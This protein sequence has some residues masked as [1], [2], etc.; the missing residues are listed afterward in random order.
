MANAA[1]TIKYACGTGATGTAPSQHTVSSGS[2][3]TPAA[4]TCTRD[5]YVFSHY[6]AVPSSYSYVNDG[7]AQPGTEYTIPFKSTSNTCT[8]NVTL[9]LTAQWVEQ[10]P[11]KT[12]SK[13][14]T[15]AQLATRQPTIAGNGANKLMLFSDTTD[16]EILNRDIV[17]TLGTPDSTTG[18]YSNTDADSAATRG[19]INKGLNR[20]QDIINGEPTQATTY[21]GTAGTLGSKPIYSSTSKAQ[22]ALIQADTLNTGIINAVNS[23]LTQIDEN[24]NPSSTGTLWRINDA[25]SI[26]DLGLAPLANLTSGATGCAKYLSGDPDYIFG[27]GCLTPL[28]SIGSWGAVFTYNGSRVQV[29][30][31]STCSAVSGTGLTS[32]PDQAAVQADYESNMALAPTPSPAG[33]YLYCKTPGAST[34]WV[35]SRVFSSASECASQGASLCLRA[36]MIAAMFQ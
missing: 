21:T 36:P 3:F 23:E 8:R 12:T 11:S 5:G 22:N 17:T 32:S 29:N 2:V 33:K 25:A 31:I 16:G 13:K 15:D 26:L 24:G 1:C 20:K 27:T 35:F 34:G 6:L 30:G 9:T 28:S 7:V 14:Y 4:N 10:N 19:A 18:L